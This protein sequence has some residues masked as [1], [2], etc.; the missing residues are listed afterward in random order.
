MHEDKSLA[1]QDVRVARLGEVSLRMMAGAVGDETLAQVRKRVAED[2]AFYPWEDVV[3]LVVAEPVDPSELVNRALVA[4][5][6]WLVT[7]DVPAAAR[8]AAP[9]APV[10]TSTPAAPAPARAG[11]ASDGPS[12]PRSEPSRPQPLRPE[13][14]RGPDAN[15]R[16][17]PRSASY[18]FKKFLAVLIVKG[19]F[20]GIALAALLVILILLERRHPEINIYDFARNVQDWFESLAGR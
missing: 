11:S 17:P 15:I 19:F 1:E 18:H 10:S 14:V 7:G 2:P 16:R 12:P 4:Q 6:D 9:P 5:R 8:V 3:R 20:Y 13:P